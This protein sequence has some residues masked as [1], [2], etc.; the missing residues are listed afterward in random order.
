M[1]I[2]W[3]TV[4]AQVVNFLVLVWLLQR[5]LYKPITKAME[6]REQRIAERLAEGKTMQDDAAAQAEALRAEH[7]DFTQQRSALMAKA[8]ADAQEKHDALVN[9]AR[10]DVKTQRA[11]WVQQ[12]QESRESDLATLRECAATQFFVLAERALQDM[13]DD[14]LEARLADSFKGQLAA[15][16]HA[17]RG[18]LADHSQRNGHKVTLES[19]FYLKEASRK[20]LSEA[21]ST[22][23]DDRAAIEFQHTPDVICGIRL[24]IAGQQLDWNFS[25]YLDDFASSVGSAYPTPIEA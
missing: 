22:H 11:T 15:L 14:M 23:I 24:S 20:S 1:Q 6:R 8:K 5:F 4:G 25:A 21:V 7:T 19:R 2:D 9:A 12:L 3:I 18:S 16:D 13:A 10:E 17:T